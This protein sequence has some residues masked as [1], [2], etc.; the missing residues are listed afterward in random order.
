MNFDKYEN[1]QANYQGRVLTL[2]MN[3]PDDLNAVNKDMHDEL[4]TIF[5]DAQ[6]DDDADVIVLTGAG[7]AFS[8]GGDMA[9]MK[10]VADGSDE[11]MLRL[12]DAKR[13]VFS[14]LDL[15]KPIIAAVN[16][17]AMGLGATIALLCDTIF[18]S[19]KAKIGDPHVKVGVVAGDGGCVIWPQLI[20][21][22]KAKEYLMTG[23]PIN[24]EAAERMGLVN[25]VTA[26]EQTLEMAQ[27]FAQRLAD[28][29]SAA[30]RWTKVSAN[31]GLKQLAHSIMDTSLAY[32]WLTFQ[33]GND[34]REAVTAFLEKREPKFTD[35]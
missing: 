1:I 7:R 22:A 18:M 6:M 28:G 25:H 32:E 16:G 31:I 14:L 13:I 8:A 10:R 20:G 9:M 27:A 23:D 12:V 15:E 35:R 11:P 19:S 5:Y 26:P 21:Y 3:R 2:T 24:A 17:H 34:H 33:T 29:P 30:I 4:G